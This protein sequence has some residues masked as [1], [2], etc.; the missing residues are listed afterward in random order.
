[1]YYRVYYCLKVNDI[2][3]TMFPKKNAMIDKVPQTEAA[4]VALVKH[5]KGQVT[6]DTLVRAKLSNLILKC[7]IKIIGV[8][9]DKFVGYGSRVG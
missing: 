1:M 8:G 5:V 3:L 4:L 2:W 6:K 9:L 7:Q